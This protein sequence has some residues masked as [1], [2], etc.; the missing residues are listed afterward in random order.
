MKAAHLRFLANEVTDEE[1]LKI[2]DWKF[3]AMKSTYIMLQWGTAAA[4]PLGCVLTLLGLDTP[5]G[6]DIWI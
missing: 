3:K 4:F 2:Q 1:F 6:S 5:V